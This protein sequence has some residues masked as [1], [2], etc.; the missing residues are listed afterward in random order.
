MAS[1]LRLFH[2]KIEP[3]FRLYNKN[4]ARFKNEIQY[5]SLLEHVLE[6]G[7]QRTDRTG[8]GT[9]SVFSP[10]PM[11]FDLTENKFPLLT[12]KEMPFRHIAEEL[13]WML[14][15]STNAKDLEAKG[16]KIWSSNGSRQN[17]DAL[18][19]TDYD[20][21]S[22]GPLYGHNWRRY[23]AAWK[24]GPLNPLAD[25]GFDQITWLQNEI[26][27]NPSS[28]RLLL[29]AYDPSSVHQA[30]LYPCHVLC[31]FYVDM[32]NKQLHSQLY[33]RS[34]DIGLGIPFNIASYALLTILFAHCCELTP[35]TLTHVLGDAH[36]YTNHI[37]ALQTQ[38]LQR[39][40]FPGPRLLLGEN[41]PRNILDIRCEHLTLTDYFSHS[42]IKMDMAL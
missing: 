4:D 33:Q 12:T 14:S 39:F 3:A 24:D 7:V 31:Q 20:D 35:G 41:C 29:T 22:L 17:L 27:T 10:Q 8:V 40:P 23:G 21:G 5:L 13:F 2:F 38:Q 37:D 9:V 1:S 19:F 25:T 28:R 34:G 42:K 32:E 6:K 11:R 18:G 15:G 26:R 36:V 16:V 30:V